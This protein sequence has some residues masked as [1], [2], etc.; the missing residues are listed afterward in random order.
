VNE[1]VFTKP[2][3][4]FIGTTLKGMH[5]EYTR[6]DIGKIAFAALASGELLTKSNSIFAVAQ[7]KP[8]SR[9]AGVYIGINA[10]ISFKGGVS[11]ADEIIAGMKKLGLSSCELRLQPVEGFIRGTGG[12]PVAGGGRGGPGGGAPNAAGAAGQRGGAEAGGASG[13]RGAAGAGGAGGGGGRAP[14]TPEQ[15]AAQKAAAEDLAKWRLSLSHDVFTAFRKKYNDEGILIKVLKVDNINTFTDDVVDYA[16]TVGK[17]LGAQALSTEI[18]L[19]ESKR[20]GQFADKHKMLIGYHG[21]T[22]V[23]DPEAFATAQSW[24]TA[25]G[26]AKYNGWNL[27][28]GHFL[29]ANSKSPLPYLDKYHDRI[30]H[31]HLKD[32]K[33]NN[34]PNM[35]WGQGDTPIVECLQLIRDKKWDIMGAIEM[36][37]PTPA[38]SDNWTE[39]AKCV[40]YCRKALLG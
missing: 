21:H 20:I 40:E 10:P 2:L 12:S 7:E 6:R 3:Y 30:S 35:P 15:L 16:F 13:Q 38:G 31:L 33:M 17:L 19:S 34:G 22:N 8:N 5:M 24:E 14:Q 28:L 29:A 11:T 9:F 4:W 18:P 26:Y 37:H 1:N 39:L 23:N 36:E 27:D 25:M 32:R